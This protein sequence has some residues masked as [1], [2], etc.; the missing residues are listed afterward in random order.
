MTGIPPA[1][2]LLWAFENIPHELQ[3]LQQWVVWRCE[4]DDKGKLKKIPINAVTG[5]NA[6]VIN[7][8]DWHGF[9]TAVAA[10]N[11]GRERGLYNG[12][13]IVFCNAISNYAGIDIDDAKGD[14]KLLLAHRRVIDAFKQHGYCEISPSGQ[15]IHI[16]VKGKIEGR[17]RFGVEAYSTG[18]F[19]TFTGHVL[20]SNPI[21]ECQPLLNE[22][23][24]E[25]APSNTVNTLLS[26][27]P[28]T[29]DDDTI[30]SRMF[31]AKNGANA[32]SL[33]NGVT[34]NP[35]ASTVDL[36]L[37]NIVVWHTKNYEQVERIWLRSKPGQRDKVQRRPAYRLMTIRKAFDRHAAE[38]EMRKGVDLSAVIARARVD[39]ERAS[40]AGGGQAHV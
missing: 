30:I 33:F 16:I 23:Q 7:A 26:F 14:A 10:Y 36:A 40:Q 20:A 35:D 24:A 17:R 4:Q 15:G 38:Q 5:Y 32:A 28:A 29:A 22:L 25:L 37:C 1:P 6:S 18:R 12:I 39:A 9:A 31:A 34:A 27:E 19:F 21:R 11:S 2:K 3:A 8:A 13:G